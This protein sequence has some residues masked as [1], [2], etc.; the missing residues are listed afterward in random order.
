MAA[1]VSQRPRPSGLELITKQGHKSFGGAGEEYLLE[2]V[3][4]E[5]SYGSVYRC[6]RARDSAVFAAK[7][8]DTLRIGFVGGSAGVQAAQH[9]AAREVEALRNLSSHRSII[10]LEAAFFSE[11]TQQIF[12]VTEFIPGSHLFSHVV[13]RTQ[14]LKEAEASHIVAQLADAVGF[15]HALG[16]VHRDLKLEN[17]LV[18]N[19]NVR[20]VEHR[21]PES[22]TVSWH[23]EEV[24]TVKICDFGFAKFCEKIT[25]RTP[26]GTGTYSAPEVR[27]N[28]SANSHVG[29]DLRSEG[30][31]SPR[32]GHYDGFKADAF[33]LGIMIFVMLCLGFP[34]KDRTQNSHRLHKLW[35]T[36]SKDVQILID[37][38]LESDPAQRFGIM[39]VC[40]STWVQ[41]IA[42]EDDHDEQEIR[43]TR[44]KESLLSHAEEYWITTCQRSAT[45]CQR[46]PQPRWR[47]QPQVQDAALP[48]VLAMHRALVHIQQERAMAC[49]YVVADKDALKASGLEGISCED[50]LKW[51]VQLTEKRIHE[52]KLLLSKSSFEQGAAQQ[53]DEL[54]SY[55]TKARQRT[56]DDDRVS[57]SMRFDDVFTAYNQACWS[58]IEIVAKALESVRLGSAEGRRAAR[59]YRLFSAAAEQLGRERA[60]MC[61]HEEEDWSPVTS[62]SE[63]KRRPPDKL[64]RLA[65]ILGARKILLGTSVNGSVIS[66]DVVATSTGLLGTLIGEDEPALLTPDDIATLESLERRVLDPSPNDSVATEEWYRTITRFLNEI[67]SRIAISL[68]EDM[69]LPEFD[70]GSSLG[71]HVDGVQTSGRALASGI[72]LGIVGKCFSICRMG[73]KRFLSQVVEMI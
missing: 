59:R 15:C 5:G 25:T 19:V 30:A 35:P 2:E 28:R 67:H 38:L 40:D 62:K 49:W 42:V 41:F 53:V 27:V 24:F 43:R 34:S 13:Q 50:Q 26:L 71:S 61:G 31:A 12:I 6:L 48:G 29:S 14:P 36:L 46:S 47:P 33:S 72:E 22:G 58:L 9:M 20:L 66:A 32:G 44:S 37:G 8:I 51:H 39:D 52:A 68:V 60:F 69:R 10:S 16:V 56:F 54:F 65:E 17:V 57:R 64:H 3:L 11:S 1:A 73:L 21:D 7:I 4:G 45:T 18:A 55:M 63:H 70:L 23:T